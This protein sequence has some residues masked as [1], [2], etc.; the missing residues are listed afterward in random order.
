[1]NNY[2]QLL[3]DSNPTL[4]SITVDISLNSTNQIDVIDISGAIVKR[5]FNILGGKKIVEID[6]HDL[7]KGVYFFATEEGTVIGKI[8]KQ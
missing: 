5:I 3:T 7:K 6:I 8:V 1:M 4:N 2:S